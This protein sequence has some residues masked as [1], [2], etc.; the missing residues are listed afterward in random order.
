MSAAQPGVVDAIVIGAQKAGS[1]SLQA[2]LAE[3]SAV[4]MTEGE[5]PVFERTDLTP[6]QMAAH[7]AKAFAPAAGRLRMIK[8]PNYL[9]LPHVPATVAALA[10]QARLIVV[11]RDPVKR[12][13]S[14]Y[15]H[16]QRFGFL[17]VEPAEEGMARVFDG[18]YDADYARAAEVRTFGRYAEGLA[19][20][21]A[22]FPKEQIW[23]TTFERLIADPGAVFDEACTFLGIA[24]GQRPDGL[25][26]VHNEGAYDPASLAAFA[27]VN[28]AFFQYT[29]GRMHRR[30]RLPVNPLAIAD[31]LLALRKARALRKTSAAAK[32][33]LSPA[34]AARL[35]AYY[36]DD[37]TRLEAEWGIRFASPPKLAA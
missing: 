24:T 15:I 23:V 29:P 6:D 2:G 30:F 27:R 36:A 10:P 34:L 25:T 26:R 33:Q 9:C 14:A 22:H 11:L 12:A 31:G 3:H 35:A 18:V 1:T 17:P 16:M 32:P 19:S 37:L 5:D 8:R 7:L 13:L 21:A 4:F 28:A 20:W